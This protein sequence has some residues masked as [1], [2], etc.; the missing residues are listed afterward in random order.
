MTFF[1]AKE[2][3]QSIKQA[4]AQGREMRNE[5][6]SFVHSPSITFISL[7]RGVLGNPLYER[8]V[9]LGHEQDMLHRTVTIREQSREHLKISKFFGGVK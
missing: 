8:K 5:K 6:R 9:I 3:K 4:P 2:E 7:K 1:S